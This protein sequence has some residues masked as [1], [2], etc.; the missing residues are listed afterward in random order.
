VTIVVGVD[1]SSRSEQALRWAAHLAALTDG[2][3]EAVVAWPPR[4][5][6]GLPW[7]PA[8]LNWNPEDD[9]TK[10]LEISLERAF[11]DAI[12]ATLRRRVVEGSAA[13]VLIDISRQATAL[14]VGSR[15]HGGFAGLLLGSVSAA[16]TEHAA[17]PV[18]V[19]HGD[20]PPPNGRTHG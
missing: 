4:F 1:G 3:V 17:C 19:V 11:G 15:G 2:D 8:G 14:V 12:P 5:E 16:C 6:W 20:T 9:A 18:L 13:R 10:I 7:I